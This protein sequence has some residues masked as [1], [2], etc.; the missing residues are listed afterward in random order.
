MSID[1][2]SNCVKAVLE[3]MN[4]EPDNE[5]IWNITYIHAQLEFRG[6]D[7]PIDISRDEVNV[8]PFLETSRRIKVVSENVCKNLKSFIF[9][10]SPYLGQEGKNMMIIGAGIDAHLIPLCRDFE[11]FDEDV[12]NVYKRAKI[13]ED[14]G[15]AE[16]ELKIDFLKNS[17][18]AIIR[19][20]SDED[21]V[22]EV[23]LDKLK[24]K[25]V[26]VF[27]ENWTRFL[28]NC[29][30]P[31]VIYYRKNEGHIDK[32]NIFNIAIGATD[33]VRT[34]DQH[35]DEYC[36]ESN[37]LCFFGVSEGTML[38][39]YMRTAIE[40]FCKKQGGYN[41]KIIFYHTLR[42]KS[43]EHTLHALDDVKVKITP[44]WYK[45]WNDLLVNLQ[46]TSGI[47]IRIIVHSSG[48]VSG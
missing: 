48:I 19:S 39:G 43:F 13:L 9:A 40:N 28:R 11:L 10:I 29:K 38:K 35:F 25:N 23:F 45:E 3:D 21:K 2:V 33:K 6:W 36:K 47:P 16:K 7:F 17:V 14:K 22:Y 12:A 20:Y 44:D 34:L 8:I 41:E 24:G 15:I 5:K 18:I 32:N 37:V 26:Y 42:W 30:D 46:Q 1:Y 4:I 27:T 31:T